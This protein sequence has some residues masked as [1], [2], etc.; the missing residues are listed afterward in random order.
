MSP[1]GHNSWKARVWSS[2]AEFAEIAGFSEQSG[3]G[4]P[5]MLARR[6][7]DESEM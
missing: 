4:D 2:M 5:G 3:R 7:A 1:R 6:L